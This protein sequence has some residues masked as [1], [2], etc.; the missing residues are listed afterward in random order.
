LFERVEN[1]VRRSDRA[2]GGNQ[3]L[4]ARF[5]FLFSSQAAMARGYGTR[6]RLSAAGR[7]F[8]PALRLCGE[9]SSGRTGPPSNSEGTRRRSLYAQF[10]FINR[11]VPSPV[12]LLTPPESETALHYAVGVCR[13]AAAGRGPVVRTAFVAADPGTRRD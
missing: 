4:S 2:R 12:R 10:E 1:C 7:S 3:D 11:T 8:Y 6:L 13:V 5:P 9:S